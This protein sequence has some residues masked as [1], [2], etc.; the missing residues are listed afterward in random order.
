MGFIKTRP[1]VGCYFFPSRRSSMKSTTIIKP[2]NIPS[3]A[4]TPSN[5]CNKGGRVPI[6]SIKVC[7]VLRLKELTGEVRN[8]SKTQ[9]RS[10]ECGNCYRGV[11]TVLTSRTSRVMNDFPWNSWKFWEWPPDC[12]LEILALQIWLMK[13]RGSSS[14]DTNS[15]QWEKRI[16]FQQLQ[17]HPA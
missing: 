16:A 6:K 17:P 3:V 1:P 9:D 14:Q 4:N 13:H 12:K 10:L 8:P 5:N 11:T 7:T 2:L 15:S